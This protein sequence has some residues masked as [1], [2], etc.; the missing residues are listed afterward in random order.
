MFSLTIQII[1]G[2]VLVVWGG[3]CT[4]LIGLA[5]YNTVLGWMASMFP[6]LFPKTVFHRQRADM[7]KIRQRINQLD[8]IRSIESKPA[9]YSEA[10][11]NAIEEILS[12]GPDFF[13]K[14]KITPPSKTKS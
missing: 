13:R 9:C 10:A 8:K 5:L 7:K 6:R 12:G 14:N 11:R 2:A 1:A 3:L 4:A